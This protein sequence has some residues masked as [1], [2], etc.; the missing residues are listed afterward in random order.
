MNY[1][2]TIL[3]FRLIIGTFRV[4]MPCTPLSHAQLAGLFYASYFLRFSEN[5]LKVNM[6]QLLMEDKQNPSAF[7]SL[8]LT[9]CI[10]C[11]VT[12]F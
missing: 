4:T 12:N 2:L 3:M 1:L 5:R 9:R 11:E 6:L 8:E 7:S 10:C